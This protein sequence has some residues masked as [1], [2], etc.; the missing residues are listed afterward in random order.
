MSGGRPSLDPTPRPH[1]RPWLLPALWLTRRA[2]L[3][4]PSQTLNR[5]KLVSARGKVTALHRIAEGVL[6]ADVD[7][8]TPSLSK[9]VYVNDLV[10]A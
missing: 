7:W 5:D 4:P 9:R 10:K 6:L 8:D 1:T 3:A 2:S